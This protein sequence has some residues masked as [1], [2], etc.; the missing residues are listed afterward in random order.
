MS[1]KKCKS[2][3][4]PTDYKDKKAFQCRKC[5][6]Q[7]NKANRLCKALKNPS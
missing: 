1:N 4:K 6:Q 5:G 7:S 2:N 3:K